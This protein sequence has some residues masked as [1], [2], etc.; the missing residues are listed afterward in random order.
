M[1][2]TRK[3]R[4]ISQPEAAAQQGRRDSSSPA[5][6]LWLPTDRNLHVLTPTQE[7]PKEQN[8]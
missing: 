3:E 5:A 1:A 8:I 7:R 4:G 2:V 6:L